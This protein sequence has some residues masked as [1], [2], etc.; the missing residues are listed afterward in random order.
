MKRIAILIAALLA[1]ATPLAALAIDIGQA[2]SQGLVGETDS[3]YIAAVSSPGSDVRALVDEV[4]GKRRQVYQDLAKKNGVPLA[5]IEKVA[6][7]KAINKTP[8]GQKVRIGGSWQ[9]K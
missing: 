8:A 2:K 4:N 3:G 9:T 1:L 5:E 6:A 7:Q